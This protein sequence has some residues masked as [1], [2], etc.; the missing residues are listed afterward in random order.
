MGGMD[1]ADL[2][3]L[4]KTPLFQALPKRH[5]GRIARLA[6]VERYHDGDVILEEG[7]VGGMFMMMLSGDAVIDASSGDRVLVSDEYFG[8]LSLID[9]RPRAAT[10][11]AAGPVKIAR[12]GR[13]DFRALL[14]EEPALAVGL[15]PGVAAVARDLLRADAAATPET[16]GVR[17]AGLDTADQAEATPEEIT[18]RDALG[19]LMLARHVGTFQALNEKQLRK[20]AKLFTIESY[21]DRDTVILAGAPGDSMHVVL[22]GRARV[23]T[24]SGHSVALGADACFGE[25]ALIDGAPRSATVTA[26]GALTTAMLKRS[27]FTKLLKGEPGIAVGLLDGLVAIVRDMEEASAPVA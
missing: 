3:A 25:L 18:G 9:G 17:G 22:N 1:P 16:V 20:V 2:K 12:I 7:D 14:N 26:V 21:A 23:R 19:W 6:R 8:E 10:V 24:P 11:T 13:E 27:D 5:R 4:E 15:L